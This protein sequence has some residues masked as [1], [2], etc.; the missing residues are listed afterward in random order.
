MPF[1]SL[2]PP[3]PKP[4]L[5]IHPAA[6]AAPVAG[7]SVRFSCACQPHRL[8][9]SSPGLSSAMG[10]LFACARARSDD[11]AQPTRETAA[12]VRELRRLD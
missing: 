12:D 9:C 8:A 1:P 3:N 11:L 4:L 7:I 2:L 6:I 5:V 10:I